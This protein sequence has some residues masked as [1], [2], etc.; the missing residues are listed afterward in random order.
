MKVLVPVKLTEEVTMKA[1]LAAPLASATSA[2]L[3]VRVETAKFRPSTVA[4]E[5]GVAGCKDPARPP[6]EIISWELAPCV[7]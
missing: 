1:Q 4:E 5:M 2:V 3:I 6:M 7:R